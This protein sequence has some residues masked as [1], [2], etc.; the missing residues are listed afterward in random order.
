MPRPALQADDTPPPDTTAPAAACAVERLNAG[1]PILHAAHFAER[2]VPDDGRNINGP[3]VVRLPDWLAP[4][5]RAHPAA[6]Y[7]LYFAHHGGAYIRMAWAAAIEGPWTL[8]NTDAS[9]PAGCGVLDLRSAGPDLAIDFGPGHA[10]F[11]QHV[12]S[13]DVHLDAPRRRFVMYFHAPTNT[14]AH[15]YTQAQKTGVATSADG[16]N[17]NR[18]QNGGQPGHGVRDALLGNAY[19]RVFPHHGHL[20]A[21]SNG[22]GLWRTPDPDNPWAPAS[23]PTD[24]AWTPGPNPLQ[25]ALDARRLRPRHVALRHLDADTLEVFFTALNDTPERL[26]RVTLDIAGPWDGWRVSDD[27]EVVL[28]AER[29]WEGG[30]LPAVQSQ[31]GAAPATR[32][33]QLRD[34]CLLTDADGS[35]YLFYVGGGEQAIGVARLTPLP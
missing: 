33:N 5:Q 27:C 35:T 18:P 29:A 7:Y 34:P 12:A 6:V 16:L 24:D 10:R 13:P 32:I 25:Q 23:T 17:F 8:Y 21:V 19:F 4:D 11:E 30:D 31:R 28:R 9:S 22:G 2:G 20:Y 1:R 3:S 26:Y 15:G 14:T